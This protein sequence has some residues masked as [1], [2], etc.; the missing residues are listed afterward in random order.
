MRRVSRSFVLVVMGFAAGV[1]V[2]V[3]TRALAQPTAG[4][5]VVGTYGVSVD[6]VKQNLVEPQL[7]T[8][9]FHRKVTLSDGSVRDITLIAVEEQGQPMVKFLDTSKSGTFEST[10]G[11]NGTTT[12]GKLMVMVNIKEGG[13]LG[14]PAKRADVR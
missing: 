13:A 14:G 4:K 11:P 2:S 8:G 10:M 3:A 6:E 1:A 7:F 9:Q 5:P 12:N